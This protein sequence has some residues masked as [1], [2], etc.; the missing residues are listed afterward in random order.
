MTERTSNQAESKKVGLIPW[1]NSLARL[2]YM[3]ILLHKPKETTK[4]EQVLDLAR[5]AKIQRVHELS[6]KVSTWNI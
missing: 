4:E 1:C 2:Q 3:A 5:K 6:E